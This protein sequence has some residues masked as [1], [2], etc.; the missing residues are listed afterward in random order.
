MKINPANLSPRDSH[1]LMV[2]AIV[3]RPIAWVSTVD[4]HGI[5]NLAPFSAF[6]I[7]S[8]KPAVV[9]FCVATRRDGQKKDTLRNIESTKDF[10]IN[11]VTESL[12]EVMNLTST[13][14]P[15]EV[16]EFTEAGLTPIKADLVKAPLVAES[17]INMECR[18]KQILRF[19]KASTS[20]SFIIGDLLLVHVKDEFY[21]DGEIQMSKLKA[22][23]RM[24]GD[25][26][27]RAQ[28]LFEMKRPVAE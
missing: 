10:V 20:D 24:G 2:G 11:V 12:A 13:P 15:H 16:S 27:C 3:P 8:L 14:F 23:G 1:H 22:I 17:P 6:C 19:G 18:I 9:G 25:I 7:V 5:Y 26:Y 4:Q 28:D 21:A